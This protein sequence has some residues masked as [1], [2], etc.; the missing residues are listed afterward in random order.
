MMLWGKVLGTLF[1]FMFGRIPGAVIGFIVGHMFDKGYSQDFNSVGGFGRFFTN[2][3]DAQKQAIFFHALFSVLGHVAKADGRVTE[4]EIKVASDLMD[5]MDLRGDTRKEAQQAFREGK[6]ADF[7]IKSIL[8]R[9]SDSCYGRKDILQVFLE[10]LIQAAFADGKIDKHEL[11]VL[12]DV[13]KHLG[14]KQHHLRFLITSYEAELRFRRGWERAKQAKEQAAK[15]RA[16][17]RKQSAGFNRG[18]G[19]NQGA[20]FNGGGQSNYRSGFDSSRANNGGSQK[21]SHQ[22]RQRYQQDRQPQYTQ[23]QSLADAYRIIGVKESDD[24]KTIKRA[25]RK[26]MTEHHPDK[27]VSK[28]L[29]KQ[30]LELAKQKT[31]DIQAAYESIRKQR[32]F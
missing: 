32:Q 5:K 28:G 31:Q 8:K 3:E 17:S 22:Y 29:P 7:P 9:F 25:Y 11:K 18:A 4:E 20:G 21:D 1:G 27:L 2:Q 15:Q 6:E 14:F 10:I 26:L 30:A 19:F 16:E 23:Q 12:E 13:A 24:A